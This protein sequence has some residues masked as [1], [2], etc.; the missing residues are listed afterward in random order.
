M[1]LLERYGLKRNIEIKIWPCCHVTHCFNA[2]NIARP[3]RSAETCFQLTLRVVPWS[4]ENKQTN[5]M[6]LSPQANYTDWST[7]TW[8]YLV[9]T[10]VDRGVSLVQRD[11]SST[12]VHLS[13]LDRRRYFSFNLLLIYPHKGWVDPVADPLLLRKS[14]SAGT[15]GFAARN[16]DYYT[17]EV[18]PWSVENI[19]N[20]PV[21]IHVLTNIHAYIYIYLCVCVCLCVCAGGRKRGVRDKVSRKGLQHQEVLPDN[22]ACNRGHS[23]LPRHYLVE[24]A[25][26]KV[27]GL[28]P[29]EVNVSIFNLFT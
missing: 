23:I 9:Q 1:Q 11:G 12:V 27:A 25:S 17:T 19:K 14:G 4:V 10:F 22:M 6:A 24:A 28:I 15:S 2:V 26:R 16:S 7:A 13:F 20:N 8:R 3:I 29:D 5:S 18:V 21:L